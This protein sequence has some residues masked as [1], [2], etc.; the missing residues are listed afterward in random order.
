M[1]TA[2]ILESYAPINETQ[3]DLLLNRE[4]SANSRNMPSVKQNRMY[5]MI[6]AEP[7]LVPAI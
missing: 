2:N 4:I 6:N 1:L 7:P 5:G 3:A